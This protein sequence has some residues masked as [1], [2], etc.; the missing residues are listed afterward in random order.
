MSKGVGQAGIVALY[1]AAVNSLHTADLPMSVSQ[2]LLQAA[3]T[4]AIAVLTTLLTIRLSQR[5][6]RAERLWDRKAAA[7]ERL[8]DAFH[9]YKRFSVD[10]LEAAYNQT[11]VDDETAAKL[12]KL[13]RES[14]DEI[15]RAQ[16]IG[17]FTIS[18][19]A[20]AILG[21]YRAALQEQDDIG[22]WHQH[23]DHE[24]SVT[25]EHM[26]ELIAEAKRDL[27]R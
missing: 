19:E 1:A 23:L 18:S 17:S 27:S 12:G 20:I 2:M 11:E 10:H 16:D 6:F 24:Y 4:L 22:V 21:R 7:Y 5:K 13:S 14:S 15:W 9:N 3:V 26:K 25:D 8:I